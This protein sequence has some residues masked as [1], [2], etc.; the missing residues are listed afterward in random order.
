MVPPTRIAAPTPAN[1][2][3]KKRLRQHRHPCADH[4]SNTTMPS[5]RVHVTATTGMVLTTRHQE[6]IRIPSNPSLVVTA[7]PPC[8]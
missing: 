6:L 8:N 7:S 1:Q 5:T 3:C 4:P 2:E